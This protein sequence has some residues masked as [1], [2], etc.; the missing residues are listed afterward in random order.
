MT[1]EEWIWTRATIAL[2]AAAAAGM[3]KTPPLPP[4]PREKIGV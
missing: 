4:P 3:K 2:I 1:K